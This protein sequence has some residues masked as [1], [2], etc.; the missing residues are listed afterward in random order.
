MLIDDQR[1]GDTRFLCCRVRLQESVLI[2]GLETNLSTQTVRL[3]EI[4]DLRI[5]PGCSEERIE[6]SVPSLT[7]ELARGHLKVFANN[8]VQTVW[9]FF[10]WRPRVLEKLG[11]LLLVHDMILS[12]V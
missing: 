3:V 8:R 2:L 7:G 5:D 12:V 6:V 1:A 10:G 11:N 4:F 9:V